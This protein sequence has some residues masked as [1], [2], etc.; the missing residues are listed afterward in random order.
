MK[1]NLLIKICGIRN[2]ESARIVLKY[3][4]SMI[5]LIFVPNT[6]RLVR[7]NEAQKIAALAHSQG[8][9]VVG[10]FQN[11]EL[12]RV[13]HL[14]KSIPLDYIQLHG[15]ESIYYCKKI[16]TPIIK[17]IKLDKSLQITKKIINKYLNVVDIFLID[18]PQQGKG[19]IVDLN[20]IGELAKEY[21]VMVAGGLN[22]DNVVKVIKKIG[23]NLLGVDVSSGIENSVGEK[24]E[25]LLRSFIKKGRNAYES[26]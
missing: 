22:K 24:E 15:E 14:I 2:E 8:I 19:S 23:K 25:Q 3:K 5:G 16:N 20:M 11:Q 12:T 17:K 1:N 21:P 10:V 6:M 7:K 9:S 26:I 13:L 4:S 18:R